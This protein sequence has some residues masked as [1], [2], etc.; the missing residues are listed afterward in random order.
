M[1]VGDYFNK[2]GD[3]VPGGGWGGAEVLRSQA[4]DIRQDS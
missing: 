4:Y 3:R 2:G 1:F